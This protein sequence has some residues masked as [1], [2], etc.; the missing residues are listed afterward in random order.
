MAV[1]VGVQ[2][3]VSQAIAQMRQFTRVLTEA[4]Q[5]GKKLN[6]INVGSKNLGGFVNQFDRM[7]DNLNLMRHQQEM[8]KVF[9][10][11]TQLGWDRNQPWKWA[12]KIPTFWENKA[13][14]A[15]LHSKFMS[16]AAYGPG[17]Q[18]GSVLS[19]GNMASQMAGGASGGGMGGMPGG[20]MIGRAGRWAMNTATSTVGTAAGLA[21]VGSIVGAIV[22]GFREHLSVMNSTESV[23][24][25]GATGESFGEVEDGVRK[26]ADALKISASEAGRLT[27]EY[28]KASGRTGSPF[29]LATNAGLF[30]RGFGMDPGHATQLFGRASLVGYG[31]DKSSQR[32]FAALLATTISSSGMYARS[33]QVMEDLVSHIGEI[34]DREGRTASEGE[35]G[36]YAGTL[37]AL[38][39]TDAMRGGAAHTFMSGLQG[40]GA[41]GDMNR[42]M[43]AWQAYGKMAGF[44]PIKMEKIK[45]AGIFA[46]G[47]DIFQNGDKT[48]KLERAMAELEKQSK[49]LPGTATEDEKIAYMM[50]IQTGMGMNLSEAGI[51]SMR[52]IRGMDGGLAGF[53]DWV[54][55]DANVSMENVNPEAIGNLAKLYEAR[56]KRGSDFRDMARNYVESYDKASDDDKASGRTKLSKEQRDRL[57]ELLASGNEEMLRLELPS[58]VAKTGADMNPA[59]RARDATTKLTNTLEQTVGPQMQKLVETFSKVGTEMAPALET[60]LGSLNTAINELIPAVNGLWNW[61]KSVFGG[62][63]SGGASGPVSPD[64][65][66]MMPGETHEQWVERQR[67]L[68]RHRF[69]LGIPGVGDAGASMGAGNYPGEGL[70][71]PA[72]TTGGGFGG[73][74]GGGNREDSIRYIMSRARSAGYSS[75]ASAAIAGNFDHETDGF[76]ALKPYDKNEKSYGWAHWHKERLD[77]F[78]AYAKANNLSPESKEANFGYFL[79][80]M[81]EGK[82]VSPDLKKRLNEAGSLK[83]ASDIFW[84]E[85]ERPSKPMADMR[86]RRSQYAMGLQSSSGRSVGRQ[87][88][89]SGVK[90]SSLNA[91]GLPSNLITTGRYAG[92]VKGLDKFI[93]KHPD[94]WQAFMAA[95]RNY[96]GKVRIH[97]AGRGPGETHNH[98]GFHALDYELER[99][100]KPGS[101]I[102]NYQ[103]SGK[104]FRA[105]E[106]FNQDTAAWGEHH[107]PGFMKRF[108]AGLYFGPSKKGKYWSDAMHQDMTPGAPQPSYGDLIHGAYPAMRE[109]LR[110][111]RGVDPVSVG[112]GDPDDYYRRRFANEAPLTPSNIERMAGQGAS[113]TQKVEGS[114]TVKI[115]LEDTKGNVRAKKTVNIGFEP[116]L[117]GSNGTSAHPDG[118]RGAW[119]YP[120]DWEV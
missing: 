3:D 81:E 39:G 50:K 7:R 24:K 16:Q 34:A 62:E 12:D 33:E 104:D 47:D 82:H 115:V 56:D 114:A 86:L 66:Q 96:P 18:V 14:G 77:D 99:L 75:I 51:R 61:L 74:E 30:G 72:Y 42:E 93:A 79:K 83:E 27:E 80:E 116:R 8:S 71:G 5:A 89:T 44:D 57:N 19:G 107:Y 1:K 92:D 90:P 20:S 111:L 94:H 54:S 2:A 55:S 4:G 32:D 11:A 78:K 64:S 112:M 98:Q 108:R 87:P 43:F 36:R 6:D 21:G 40:L 73:E 38:Y 120:A 101:Y 84:Q 85:F 15:D 29:E 45:D 97:D 68:G 102:P 9:S 25:R 10:R 95:T 103:V 41:G 37:A 52:N 113:G 59:E 118:T 88:I 23:Y 110:K 22:A 70:Q 106:Q 65:W 67:G 117:N 105:Y 60:A 53:K 58:I 49:W 28:V 26:L 76:K 31:Q 91:S 100:D 63:T 119:S 13:K 35:V 17:A 109:R 46:S 69:H 48:T